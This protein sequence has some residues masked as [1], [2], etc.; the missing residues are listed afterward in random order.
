MNEAQ[1]DVNT[2]TAKL[3]DEEVKTEADKRA[4]ISK[5][6][7]E[8]EQILLRENMT[9]GDFLEIVGLFTNRANRVFSLK[10]IKEIN[11]TYGNS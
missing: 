8:I 1:E 4:T 7:L 10:T 2:P 11:E 6:T 9:M 3:M 5:V